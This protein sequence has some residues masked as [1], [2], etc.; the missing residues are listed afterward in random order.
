MA[1]L[2]GLSN[3]DREIAK[4]V[5]QAREDAGYR[6]EDVANVFPMT[7]ATTRQGRQRKVGRMMGCGGCVVP[8]MLVALSIAVIPLLL[9]VL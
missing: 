6:Q 2:S 1:N 3:R 8:A 9:M 4:R 7:P 5:R